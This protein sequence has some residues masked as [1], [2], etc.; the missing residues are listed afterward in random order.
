MRPRLTLSAVFICLVCLSL[1]AQG[2]DLPQPCA[3]ALRQQDP[4][5]T[6]DLYG[7]C[8]DTAALSP[9]NQARIHSNRGATFGKLGQYQRA[10]D[11][12]GQ[13]I[14]L[15]PDAEAFIRRAVVYQA[16]G[17]MDEAAADVRRARK[18]DP[19]ITVPPGI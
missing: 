1:P 8:L 11:E 9:E 2:Q 16:L 18:L 6:V 10:L 5:L 19:S 12:L 14:T 13:A 3:D 15:K 4:Q 17:R 7:R